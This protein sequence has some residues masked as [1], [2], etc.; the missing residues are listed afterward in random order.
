MHRLLANTRLLVLL[1]LTIVCMAFCSCTG[2]NTDNGNHG[3]AEPVD[4]FSYKGYTN[5]ANLL[6]GKA[7]TVDADFMNDITSSPAYE[8]HKVAMTTMWGRYRVS[9]VDVIRQW[10]AENLKQNVDTVFYPFGGPDFN[11]LASFF[12]DCRFS[13]LVGIEDVGKLPFIDQLSKSKYQ[14]VLTGMRALLSSNV[15]LSYFHTLSMEED[16][17]CY[18]KGTMP[19]IMMYAALHGYDVIT[20][21]P[22]KIEA[23]GTLSYVEPDKIFAHTMEK[24]AG[25]GFEMLYRKPGEKGARKAYYLNSDLSDAVFPT[26]GMSKVIERNFKGKLTFVKVASYL[27]HEPDFSAVKKS[28]LD[29]SKVVI[30][31]P[32]G[33][34]FE[35]YDK[36]LWDLKFYGKY[37]API[38]QFADYP[39]ESLKETYKKANASPINFRF[40]YHSS[41]SFIMATKK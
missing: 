28:L 8:T 19:V 7:S 3:K 34:P 2:C 13:I 16:L 22:V 23:D 10:S 9:D 35:A 17:D 29:N 39:Q 14:E 20:I 5:L 12:P 25:D 37:I 1:L 41:A 32:S 18:L 26:S 21:N 30:S 36:N 4:T 38:P 33:M 15:G 24:K 40:D 31:G 11:Y 27:L 6:A